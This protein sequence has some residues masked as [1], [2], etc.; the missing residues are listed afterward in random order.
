MSFVLNAVG[1]R[2]A[3]LSGVQVACADDPTALFSNPA[4]LG[5]TATANTM[6][7]AITPMSWGRSQ[8]SAAAAFGMGNEFQLGVGIVGF[9]AGTVTRRDALGTELGTSR[10]WQ[11]YGSLAFS[12]LFSKQSSVGSA[13]RLLGTTAPD[14]AQSGIG[15]ALDVGYITSLLDRATVGI[16]IQNLGVMNIGSE[17]FALPWLLRLGVCTRIPF[18]T[19]SREVVSPTLA[20]ADT[21]VI[22]SIEGILLGM[23]AHLRAK[24]TT[25]TIVCGIDAVIHKLFAVRTGIAMYGDSNGVPRL[26]PGSQLSGGISLSLPNGMRFDYALARGQTTVLLHT[27]SI[28]AAFN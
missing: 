16:T 25:P 23:E 14:P 20:T 8:I 24:A 4:C 7:V 5:Y 21:V 6:S 9:N 2:A 1:A 22:E 26:F 3:G 27:L 28:V 18:E 11:G 12:Y 19:H 17:R 15:T 10:I 13:L